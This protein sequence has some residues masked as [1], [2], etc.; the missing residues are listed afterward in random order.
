[1]KKTVKIVLIDTEDVKF[2]QNPIIK[3]I[4]S[5]VEYGDEDEDEEEIEEQ[6]SL[7][8]LVIAGSSAFSKKFFVAQY[9][10]AVI[11]SEKFS[12]G[13]YAIRLEDKHI[14]KIRG[15]INLFNTFARAYKWGKVV[16]TNN[17]KYT[18]V[19]VQE[20]EDYFN[21]DDGKKLNT[22]KLVPQLDQLFLKEFVDLVIPI[23]YY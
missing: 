11:F 8:E 4:K 5:Y 10:Y 14:F 1:M 23:I 3:C 2:K 7:G 19:I 13:E 18:D 6:A 20:A 16:A 21:G 15:D 12:I 17:P 9:A 22:N